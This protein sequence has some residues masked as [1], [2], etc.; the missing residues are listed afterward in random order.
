MSTYHLD[1]KSCF[2]VQL[3]VISEMCSA[4]EYPGPLTCTGV[5]ARVSELRPGVV[6][7][8]D[9]ARANSCL[10][11]HKAV[12]LAV[13]HV[14]GPVWVVSSKSW[15]NLLADDLQAE[16]QS[17]GVGTLTE[18][19]LPSR[20]VSKTRGPHAHMLINPRFPSTCHL[21]LVSPPKVKP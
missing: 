11:H 14:Q 10:G 18:V 6:T 3:A 20:C 21:I 17:G 1:R 16:A 12:K 13:D 15:R 5:T 9:Q 4:L 2:V 19:P 7:N 8:V